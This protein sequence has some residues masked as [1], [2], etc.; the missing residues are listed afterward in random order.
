MKIL[1]VDAVIEKD[2][3][4][5]LIRRGRSVFVGKL[6]LPGGRVNEGETVEEAARR[7]VKEETGLDIELTDILGVYSDPKRDPRG[8][9]ISVTFVGKI[10]NGEAKAG[11]DAQSIEWYDLDKI[12]FKA[13]AFDHAKIIK[14][15][16][17]WK[18]KK[19]TYWSTK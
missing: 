8:E 2:G 4:I 1:A 9:V 11:D 6:A 15:Y 5:I 14:D 12:D 17:G 3:R 19:D 16:L 18:K 13:L 10:I 7:E